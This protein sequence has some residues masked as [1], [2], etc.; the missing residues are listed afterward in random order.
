MMAIGNNFEFFP[1][2]EAAKS[3]KQ[4]KTFEHV[5]DTYFTEGRL[6]VSEAHK[7]PILSSDPCLLG[8]QKNSKGSTF[9]I[10]PHTVFYNQTK[11]PFSE[12]RS[13]NKYC[14][15]N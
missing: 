4:I 3:C 2:T 12:L 9:D 13:D 5:V 7:I 10:F 14:L 6:V 11:S 1:F 15:R 8:R